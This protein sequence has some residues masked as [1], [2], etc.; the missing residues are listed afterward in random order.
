MITDRKAASGVAK[1][2]I[3]IAFRLVLQVPEG[4]TCAKGSR[5][6]VPQVHTLLLRPDV[7]RAI[8]GYTRARLTRKGYCPTIAQA[9]GLT[10]ND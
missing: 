8:L 4:E 2:S 9:F 3:N 6:D 5:W 1:N 7:R 10:F